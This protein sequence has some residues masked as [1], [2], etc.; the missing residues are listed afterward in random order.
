MFVTLFAGVLHLA[1]GHLAYCNAGHNAPLVIGRQVD[2]LPCDPNLPIGVMPGW[3]FS[4]QETTLPPHSTL[5]V[6]TD[7]LNEAEDVTHAQF[8]DERI[9]RLARLLQAN[10]VHAPQAIIR[11]MTQAVCDFVGDAEQSDDLTM[12][13][14]QYVGSEFRDH[15]S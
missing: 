2:W 8:G 5:F 15:S 13:A 12:L 7:G 3:Q 6:F 11:Q 14:I 10:D 1:T 9:L 4:L